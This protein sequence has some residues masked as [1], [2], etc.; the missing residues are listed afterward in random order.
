[1]TLFS[2]LLN[3]NNGTFIALFNVAS[4]QGKISKAEDAPLMDNEYRLGQVTPVNKSPVATDLGNLEKK[5][6]AANGK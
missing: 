6:S 3:D 4:L 5:V 2:A 1:M